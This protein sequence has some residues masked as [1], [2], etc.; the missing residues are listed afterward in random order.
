MRTKIELQKI[1][2][3]FRAK[4]KIKSRSIDIDLTFFSVASSSVFTRSA[5]KK[6]SIINIATSLVRTDTSVVNYYKSR[7]IATAQQLNN[8]KHSHSE[9]FIKK[10]FNTSI[11]SQ[12]A[13]TARTKKAIEEQKILVKLLKQTD[14]ISYREDQE[15]HREMMNIKTRNE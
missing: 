9:V 10:D 7:V 2:F 11:M 15:I 6:I 12:K 5:L 1:Q 4:E 8:F 13:L 14:E 3:V